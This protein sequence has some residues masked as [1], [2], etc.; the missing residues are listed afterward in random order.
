[1]TLR[2]PVVQQHDLDL[3]VRTGVLVGNTT[4]DCDDVMRVAQFWSAALE[5][6]VDDGASDCLGA[7]PY[8]SD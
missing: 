7:K 5:R 4:V 8:T 1:V 6:P 2:T 3:C